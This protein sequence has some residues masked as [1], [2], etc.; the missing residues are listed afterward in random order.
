[1][2]Q[3]LTKALVD[4]CV[5]QNS[6]L[7]IVTALGS[8]PDWLSGDTGA[9][10]MEDSRTHDEEPKKLYATKFGLTLVPVVAVEEDSCFSKG[11]LDYSLDNT[12]CAFYGTRCCYR[13][14]DSKL[15]RGYNCS[16]FVFKL[17]PYHSA[18][19]I[20]RKLIEE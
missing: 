5:K 11:P 16:G 13:I 8:D 20:A 12:R 17:E 2:D 18:F 4:E 7:P 9:Q 1:M 19:D 10:I 14:P 15:Y 6:M 3:R